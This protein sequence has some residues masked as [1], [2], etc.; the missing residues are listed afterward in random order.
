MKDRHRILYGGFIKGRTE[1]LIQNLCPFGQPII[2]TVAY[3]AYGGIAASVS[4]FLPGP[5]TT[6]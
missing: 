1:V 2:L 3:M 4:R 5:P 6:L